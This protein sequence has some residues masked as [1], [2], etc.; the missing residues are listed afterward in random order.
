MAL[1]ELAAKFGISVSTEQLEAAQ[2]RITGFASVLRGASA[3]GGG[4]EPSDAGDTSAFGQ[5]K[6]GLEG[7]AKAAA[8]L[9]VFEL[10]NR[11]TEALHEFIS[12][13]DRINDVAVRFGVT[14]EELQKFQYAAQMAGVETEAMNK[15]LGFLQK[16]MGLAIQGNK[17]SA[18]AFKDLGIELKDASGNVRPLT[19][20]AE[21]V[22]EN[23]SKAG[24]EAEMAGRLVHIFGKEAG[25]LVPLV[26]GGSAGLQEMFEE[27]ERLG[28]GLD[29]N[30]IKLAAESDDQT[31]RLGM[32][33]K[34]LK[35]TILAE[36]LP[37]LIAMAKSQTENIANIVRFV[38]HTNLLRV[39]FLAL[40]GGALTVTT[41]K[42]VQ[43]ARAF[44]GLQ[45]VL[46]GFGGGISGI[47]KLGLAGTATVAAL[48]ALVLVLE[49]LYTL[50]TG[51]ESLIGEIWDE[52]NGA[53]SSKELVDQ[54]NNAGVMLKQT[55]KELAP[56]AMISM[57]GLLDALPVIVPLIIELVKQTASAGLFLM[58]LAVGAKTLYDVAS[59]K[60][61]EGRKKAWAA[62]DSAISKLEV[63]RKG[64]Q[65]TIMRPDGSVGETV[66]VGGLTGM[67]EEEFMKKA[68]YKFGQFSMK[69]GEAAIVPAAPVT[70][71]NSYVFNVDGS[72][73]PEKT[74][75]M[76]A[77]KAAEQSKKDLDNAYAQNTRMRRSEK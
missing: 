41:V 73:S 10:A 36:F 11:A 67:T 40:S 58:Q 53:G 69:T 22:A 61:E 30:F 7:I 57:K 31:N 14:T 3:A 65:R 18:D 24:S 26:K 9:A 21:D 76:V 62:G 16:N 32:S 34:A 5:I 12:E 1:R 27:F 74:A 52:L 25:G 56:A 60:D 29:D 38:K 15:G 66:N 39:A 49:D 4:K 6:N 23:V 68:G 37:S 47:F 13:G 71:N 64:E 2:K 8:G 19:D 77:D 46:G 20:V 75:Q 43:M 33:M 50:A 42:V 35:S 59:A 55:L 44:K 63:A 72:F 48:G 45:G 70:Q 17:A 28:G 51:G 54:L